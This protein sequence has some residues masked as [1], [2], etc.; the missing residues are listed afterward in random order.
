M[1]RTGG[2]LRRRKGGLGEFCCRSGRELRIMLETFRGKQA[3][4]RRHAFAGSG[5][6]YRGQ[7]W[8]NVGGANVGLQTTP[9]DPARSIGSEGP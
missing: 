3:A 2:I 9:V 6:L 7:S 4:L 1:L 8:G 5:E